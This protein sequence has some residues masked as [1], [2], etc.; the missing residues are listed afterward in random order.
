MCWVNRRSYTDPRPAGSVPANR[1]LSQ[2]KASE[3]VRYHEKATSRYSQRPTKGLFGKATQANAS[4]EVT[5]QD[6]G[7]QGR[8]H[9]RQGHQGQGSRDHHKTLRRV[10]AAGC[11][12]RYP[13]STARARVPCAGRWIAAAAGVRVRAGLAGTLW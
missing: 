2:G 3:A 11:R 6:Q 7:T 9:A 13:V 8:A 5:Q 12:R 1:P 4:G 10:G